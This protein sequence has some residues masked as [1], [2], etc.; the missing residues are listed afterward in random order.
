MPDRAESDARERILETAY[1]LFAK[2]SIVA[3]GKGD[4]QGATPARALG[5]IPI[6]AHR[7]SGRTD[8]CME[9]R[10]VRVRGI[11]QGVGFRPFVYGLAR[12]RAGRLGPE[13]RGWRH[14]RS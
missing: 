9:R 12:C 2:N 11:V 6:D 8:S 10:R 7:R 4:R 1:E 13:R 5:R 3:V 14:D